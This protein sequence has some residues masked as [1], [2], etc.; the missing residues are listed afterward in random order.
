[1]SLRQGDIAVAEYIMKFDRGC[2][3]VPVI[4]NDVAEK[5]RHFTDGLK[6]TI[7]GDVMMMDPADYAAASTRVFQAEQASKDIDFE[8]QRDRQQSR[9]FQQSNK[10]SYTGPDRVQG[11]QKPQV[12]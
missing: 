10:R 4:A 5:L 9:S 7:R 2:H 8:M 3:F 1:M 11:H 12:P 6:P